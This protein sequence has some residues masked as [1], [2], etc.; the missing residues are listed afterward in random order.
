MKN[1]PLLDPLFG[2]LLHASADVRNDLAGT[3][4]RHTRTTL[5]LPPHCHADSRRVLG[6]PRCSDAAPSLSGLLSVSRYDICCT[7]NGAL[8]DVMVSVLGRDAVAVGELRSFVCLVRWERGISW[9]GAAGA[10]L[11]GMGTHVPGSGLS[12][13]PAVSTTL[14]ALEQAMR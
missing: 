8:V 9:S 2:T 5:A 12:D 6:S 3:D 14:V 4:D 13:V 11:I 10:V 1:F 7:S